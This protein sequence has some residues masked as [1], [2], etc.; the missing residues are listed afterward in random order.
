MI[1][2]ENTE[3]PFKDKSNFELNQRLFLYKLISNPYL[4]KCG[5]FFITTAVFLHLPIKWII[6]KT[7]FYVFCGGETLEECKTTTNKLNQAN[8]K[9]ILDLSSEGKNNEFSFNLAIDT[10]CETIMFA[11]KNDIPFCVVKPTA[12]ARFKLL[13]K[14]NNNRHLSD[15]EKKELAKTKKRF[16]IICKK[17]TE[18]NVPILFDA[19][20]S[21][22]Q[23]ACDTIIEELQKNYNKKKIIVF[24][25]YQMYRHDRLKYLQQIISN[26]NK[27]NY[28]IGIKLVRGAYMEKERMRARR[29]GYMCPINKTKEDTDKAF[30]EALNL[31]IKNLNSISLFIGSHNEQSC[32]LVLDLI[33]KH[34]ISCNDKRIFFSQ[35]YG[36][37]DHISFNLA[38]KGYNVVKYVPYGP[39]KEV[40]PY[41][42]RRAQENTSVAGQTSRELNLIKKELI[43]RKAI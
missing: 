37:S 43:R 42:I 16:N 38:S 9:T 28:K 3:I 8:I 20:E 27:E 35:L 22:I 31:C 26:A 10:I 32:L 19:E 29:K 40:L 15:N 33:K 4:V 36:M 39:I 2:F 21:W 5:S 30:N 23:T 7:M 18:F 14:I 12:I 41:L 25:T 6:K 24:N 34:N 11:H 1:S 17:A 13:H